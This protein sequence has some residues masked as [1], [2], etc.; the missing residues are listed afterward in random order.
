MKVFTMR[1]VALCVAL[2]MAIATKAEVAAEISQQEMAAQIKQLQ[3]SIAQLQ[4]KVEKFE[5]DDDDDD[6]DDKKKE[7]KPVSVEKLPSVVAQSDVK[8]KSPYAPEFYGA[9]MAAFN[10]STNN[11]ISRFNVRNSRFGFKGKASR[12]LNYVVQIDFHNQGSVSVLDTY[13]GYKHK[14][15]E[16][17]M[18]QQQIHLTKDSDRGPSSNLFTTRSIAAIYST[19]YFGTDSNGDQYIKTLGTRDIGVYGTYKIECNIPI[20]ISAGIF[21]GTGINNADWDNKANYVARLTMGGGNGLFGGVS[22][23][24]GETLLDQDIDIYSGELSYNNDKFFVEALYQGRVVTEGGDSDLMNIFVVQGLYKYF[25]PKSRMFDYISP[26]L[27]WDYGN[28]LGYLNLVE[29]GVGYSLAFVE[30]IDVNRLSAVVNIGLKEG[31]IRSRISVGY[32]KVFMNYDP[33]DFDYN[34][35]MHDKF[36]LALVAAF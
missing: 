32:E 1:C 30:L 4:S 16:F 29:E 6:D 10:V 7:T 28:N 24:T 22:Y 8:V 31:R 11:G 3:E 5:A 34:P 19:A 23:Y 27:R 35:L 14:N 26:A 12:D 18:G 20:H 25:T 21:N 15:F 9:L 13:L 17:K 2:S 33:A 36:I